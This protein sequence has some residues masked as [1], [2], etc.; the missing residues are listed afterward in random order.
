MFEH[1]FDLLCYVQDLWDAT[2]SYESFVQGRSGILQRLLGELGWLP[3]LSPEAATALGTSEADK[4][5]TQVNS[6]IF[7]QCTCVI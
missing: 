7:V 5:F 2:L 4:L 6:Y 3:L 1:E